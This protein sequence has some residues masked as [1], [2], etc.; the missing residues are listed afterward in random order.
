[1]SGWLWLARIL[2]SVATAKRVTGKTTRSM[3]MLGFF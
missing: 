1:M 2:P 3:R